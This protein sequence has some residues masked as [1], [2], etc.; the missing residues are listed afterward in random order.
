[1]QK[2]KYSEEL[3]VAANQNIN[4]RNYWL[5]K[6]SRDI[7]KNGFPYDSIKET[8]KKHSNETVKFTF[9]PELFTR[10]ASLSKDS[11]YTIHVILTAGLNILL[12]KYTGSKDIIV[13]TPIYK[14]DVK[15]EFIN[16]VLALRNQ[17][18]ED[19]TFKELLLQVRQTIIEAAENQNYPIE[20]LLEQ[21]GIP[22]SGNEFPLF[23]TALL[24]ENI[25]DK[26]YIDHIRPNMIFSFHRCD[27]RIEGAVGYNSLLYEKATIERITSHFTYLQKQALFD[28]DLPISQ[29]EILSEEEKKQLLYEFNDTETQYPEDKMLYQ[30]FEEQVEKTPGEIALIFEKQPL[31]YREL[32]ERSN[33]LARLLRSRG[34]KP[35][36]VVGLMADI[37]NETI[38]GMIGILKAGGAFLPI[39]ADYPGHRI[40]Y[41]IEDSKP[42]ILLT[43]GPPADKIPFSGE[44]IDLRDPS[45]FTGD[46][47][48]LESLNQPGHLVYVM[49]TSGSTIY[50]PTEATI[51]STYYECKKDSGGSRVPIGRPLMNYKIRVLGN[52]LNLL[53]IGVPGQ[54]FIA[55]AGIARG[56]FNRPEETGEIERQLLKHKGIKDAVIVAREDGESDKYLCAYYVSGEQFEAA[57]LRRTLSENLPPHMVP[58]YFVRLDKIPLT[59]ND[60]LNYKALPLPEAAPL[61]EHTAPADEVEEMLA[62]IWSQLLNTVKGNPVQRVHEKL[63]FDIEYYEAGPG[64]PGAKPKEIVKRFVRTFDLSQAPLLRVG[65]CKM[66][67]KKHL[68]LVDMHHI[69]AD[70]ISNEI[71]V[72][73]FLTLYRG[74]E[75]PPLRLRYKDYSQWQNRLVASGE[76]ERQESYWLARFKGEIPALNLPTDYP[77]PMVQSFE[78][79]TITFEIG[80]GETQ[81]L[82]DL[83]QETDATLFMVLLAAFNVLLM[84]LGGQEDIVV[85]TPIAGRRHVELEQIIGMF[86][87]TPP[88]RNNPKGHNKFSE[89]V[90]KVRET[91][92]D[93]FENQE[94]QFEDLVEKAAPRRDTSRNPLFDVMFSLHNLAEDH[95]GN[96]PGENRL[97]KSTIEDYESGISKFDITLTGM[98]AAYPRNKTIH[99]LFR[100]QVKQAPANTA[101][102]EGNGS[103][104][105]SYRQLDRKSSQLA[106]ALRARGVNKNCIVGLMVER[107]VMMMVGILGIL[108]AGAAYVIYTSGSTGK[109]K[110][111]VVE[112]RNVVNFVEGITAEI[113]FTA[114]K[115]ILALTTISFDIFLLETLLPLMKGLKVVIADKIQQNDP[116]ALK[117]AII[118]NNVNMLQVTPSRLALLMSSKVDMECLKHL[119]ELMVGGEVFPDSL[120]KYLKNESKF[121]IYNLYGPT[122]TTIW[123]TLKDVT[124][125]NKINI[126]APIANTRVFIVD[127]YNRLQPIGIVGEL[128]IEGDGLARGYLN[129]PELTAEMFTA[130]TFIGGKRLYRTGDLARW[131]LNG[132]IE[133][134]GR[135]DYQVKIRGFRI[136]LGEIENRLLQDPEIEEAVVTDREKQDG[137]KY[138]CAYMVSKKELKVSELRGYL[139][140]QL[141]DYM[142]PSYFVRLDKIPLNPSGKID[143]K[144]LPPPEP[145]DS[146]GEYVAPRNDKEKIIAETWKE[147][148]GVDKVSILDNF[149]EVGGNSLELIRVNSRLKEALKVDLPVI[150]MFRYPTIDS[151]VRYLNNEETGGIITDE[152]IDKFRNKLA[153]TLKIT[154]G[155]KN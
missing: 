144:Q 92:L 74:E 52:R 75:L 84:K 10:L 4:A 80:T 148:L 27:H 64:M 108:K 77:R 99:E 110:G 128:Y 107:T 104:D 87:N 26:T 13:G 138:L 40:R 53:P 102:V 97:G 132:D 154:K 113:D 34:I 38:T 126:G 103:R 68:L 131:R 5:N 117:D 111:V 11:D 25:H 29:I 83:C 42:G 66:G 48:N 146:G 109:P 127:P 36:T 123:S 147:V 82:R 121:K 76:I 21:L 145:R 95:P 22:V 60:K 2:R 88:L 19:T 71:L 15:T 9:P 72:G 94:Y 105:L 124:R 112:H 130:N 142:I 70:G 17:L 6:L 28:P 58:A 137:Q 43:A 1:M 93:A 118:K 129:R 12:S 20:I 136:E 90:K 115:T 150:T 153:K 149:F 65:L 24:F 143:R 39:D 133:C 33:Q 56:Y 37:S 45:I 78:G 30:L 63:A 79:K 59:A 3:L 81:R 61:N 67:E 7:V 41:I 31:T 54:I 134:L 57:H 8:K 86:L 89:F 120:L 16:T 73:D 141:P 62:G 96:T 55:G 91:T 14:Q 114:G 100:D 106:L 49:Y 50:G 98:E 101:A 139:S 140:R 122:E 155:A 69:V 152:K 151:L 125:L 46:S 23:D 116:S 135:T 44:I 85:G 35:E 119:E 32:N 18:E 51:N 47:S